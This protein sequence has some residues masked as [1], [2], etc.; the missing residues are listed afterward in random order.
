M[1][2]ALIALVLIIIAGY[3]YISL[4]TTKNEVYL[5]KTAEYCANLTEQ[6]TKIPSSFI[7]DNLIVGVKKGNDDE[8]EQSISGN[9]ELNE[10]YR[11][12]HREKNLSLYYINVTINYQANNSFNA[13]LKNKSFC[14]FY[15]HGLYDEMSGAP[16]M[17][18]IMLGDKVYYPNDMILNFS[19]I[20]AGLY[21]VD[22]INLLDKIQYL[23]NKKTVNIIYD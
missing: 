4:S 3:I 23:L 8:L 15:T 16:E 19:E 14:K 7:V 6:K 20:S 18:A 9:D 5:Y 2:K 17:T 12:M 21:D 22:K 10:F 11:R 1:K 13:S